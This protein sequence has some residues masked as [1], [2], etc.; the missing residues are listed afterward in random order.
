MGKL[1]TFLP[2]GSIA[3]RVNLLSAFFAGLSCV[4]VYLIVALLIKIIQPRPPLINKLIPAFGAAI[5]F[6]GSNTFWSQAAVAEV[7]TLYVFFVGLSLLVL[8]KW[9]KNKKSNLLY[10]FSFLYGVS[11]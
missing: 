2:F 10:W 3:Y 9:T 7:Y 4:I 5:T 1:F 6:A 8:I 11:Y